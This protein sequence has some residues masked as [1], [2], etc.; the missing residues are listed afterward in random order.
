MGNRKKIRAQQ[1]K[2]DRIL[3]AFA[4][5]RN[6]PLS[7]RKVRLVADLVRG[8]DVSRAF[9]ILRYTRRNSAPHIEKLLRSA[10]A[11]W[12]MKNENRNPEDAD[13]FIKTIMVDEGRMLKRVRPRAQG[14]GGRILKRSCHITLELGERGQDE[15]EVAGRQPRDEKVVTE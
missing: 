2:E 13:L 3:R 9:G 1:I 12:Q 4:I 5:L 10:I 11:N 6:C 15:L 8:K 14:R 7:P